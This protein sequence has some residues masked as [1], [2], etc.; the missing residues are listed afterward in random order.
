MA[1]GRT[2]YVAG[3]EVGA[4]D[5]NNG[6]HATYQG[7]IRGPWSTLQHAASTARAGDTIRVQAGVYYESNI[8]FTHSGQPGAPITVAAEGPAA[9]IIDGSKAPRRHS[10]IQIRAGQGHLVISGLTVRDMP[11]NGISTD[12]AT[13]TPY[14]HITIHN[15]TLYHNGRSGLRLAAVDGFVVE[16]VEAYANGFYGLEIAASS[17]GRISA[18]N[19]RVASSSF[20]DHTG[21]KGQGLAINQGHDI[22]V[23]DCEA[24][25]N[26]IHGF[27]LS[28]WPKGGAL[29][30]D[31]T[32][33][34]NR[35][36]DNGGAGFAINSGSH[37]A[38]FRRNVA[39]RNGAEWGEEGA[40]P[41]FLCYESCWRV[42]WVH[43]TSLL[44]SDAGY[45]VEPWARRY[46]QQGERLLTYH[47]NIAFRNGR[48]EGDPRPALVIQGSDWHVVATHNNWSGETGLQTPVVTIGSSEMQS[49]S[50][51]P[52]EINAGALQE[53][54]LS[55]NP[56]FLDPVEPDVHLQRG[57]PCIDA[58][59][60]L[61]QPYEGRAPD[62]G[63]HEYGAGP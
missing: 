9:V 30:H 25:H 60:D 47:N 38:I 22:V 10:G 34:S 14:A 27:E 58:G 59:L 45:V 31:V 63:A 49:A 4:S 1:A 5:A 52:D 57:S 7:G 18:A 40:S 62:M 13:R 46:G 19:G 8:T 29:S 36:H 44:N 37:Q 28:D 2:Y 20:H 26:R 6:L 61:G 33:A 50:Y 15:C 41:G 21:K 35:S 23:E 11:R 32:F 17:R 53:G 54:N 39:W 43:N 42:E 51:T 12:A 16:K 56:W 48:Q 24:Y 3:T 55:L